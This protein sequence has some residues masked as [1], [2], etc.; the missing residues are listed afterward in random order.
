V[1]TVSGIICSE[2]PILRCFQLTGMFFCPSIPGHDTYAPSEAI[3]WERPEG[4]IHI[5][6][7]EA[8]WDYLTAVDYQHGRVLVNYHSAIHFGCASANRFS[9]SYTLPQLFIIW[10]RFVLIFSQIRVIYSAYY[11]D[12]IG[13]LVQP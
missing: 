10:V 3:Q 11:L 9:A 12:W 5:H 1:L 13:Y 7:T 6:S 8:V 4:S 2:T